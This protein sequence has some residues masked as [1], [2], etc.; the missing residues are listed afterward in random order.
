MSQGI[1]PT[2]LKIANVLPLYKADD[3]MVFNNY[4]PVSILCM[5]SKVFEKVMYSR[6]IDFLED[7]K[8]LFVNQ[9]GFRKSHSSYMALMLLVDKLTKALEN[10]VY[11]ICVFLDFSKAFDTVNH[12]VL[13][14]KLD[15]Y[16]IRG[17]ALAWFESY[18]T[19]RQQYVTYNGV[20]SSCKN[21]VWCATRVYT[22]P[23]FISFIHQW[24]SKNL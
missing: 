7:D 20:K 15:Y 10:G 14:E 13:L 18:L 5:L 12:H 22:R 11:I 8:I 6:L 16:G 1:F 19:N 4:R 17:S 23:H 2:E 21:Q 24:F 9:F 3:C